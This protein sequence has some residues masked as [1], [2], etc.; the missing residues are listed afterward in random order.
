MLT[1]IFAPFMV[2]G[3]AA[4]VLSLLAAVFVVI[5]FMLID[6]DFAR[7]VLLSIGVIIMLARWLGG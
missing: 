6:V 1:A 3:V 4:I 7:F 2:A 5:F